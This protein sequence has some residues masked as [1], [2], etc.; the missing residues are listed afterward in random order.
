[1]VIVYTSLR[2]VVVNVRPRPVD[3]D[4]HSARIVPVQISPV[5]RL[6]L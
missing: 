6:D 3:D 5:A 2:E 4:Q 1:V